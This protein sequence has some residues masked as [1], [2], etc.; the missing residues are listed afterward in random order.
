MFR[1][2]VLVGALSITAGVFFAQPAWVQAEIGSM[3]AP[4]QVMS[5][6]VESVDVSGH[7]ISVDT[8]VMGLGVIELINVTPK[9]TIIK[10]SQSIALSEIQ[11]GEQIRVLFEQKENT[12][13]KI[14]QTITVLI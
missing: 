3:T 14:A 11:S 9:T 4:A 7:M 6:T 10:G 13:L 8:S 2:Q 12:E 5:G 1:N